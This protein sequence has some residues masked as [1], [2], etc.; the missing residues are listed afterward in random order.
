LR[1][2]ERLRT[3]N[4]PVPTVI[5]HLLLLVDADI[6]RRAVDI[7]HFTQNRHGRRILFRNLSD[8]DNDN[9]TSLYSLLF[10]RDIG[11]L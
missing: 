6:L 5:A 9:L 3:T 7:E 4:E 8:S 1:L 11:Y 10:L 2:L